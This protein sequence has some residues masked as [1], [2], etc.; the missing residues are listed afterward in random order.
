MRQKEGGFTPSFRVFIHLVV[1]CLTATLMRHSDQ[2][3]MRRSENSGSRSSDLLIFHC[4]LGQYCHPLTIYL[5]ISLIV[6]TFVV[7]Y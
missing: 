4:Y 3:A 5:Q 7:D 6:I 2:W 1:A